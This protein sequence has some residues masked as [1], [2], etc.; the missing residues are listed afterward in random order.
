MPSEKSTSPW[1]H[2]SLSTQ[3]SLCPLHLCHVVPPDSP[4]FSWQPLNPPET[5]VFL[6]QHAKQPFAHY[7]LHTMVSQSASQ[8]L[9]EHDVMGILSAKAST[10]INMSFLISIHCRTFPGPGCSHYLGGFYM[11]VDSLVRSLTASFFWSLRQGKLFLYCDLLFPDF[12][13]NKYCLLKLKNLVSVESFESLVCCL[14][15]NNID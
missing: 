1:R 2:C 12:F 13:L 15:S 6:T 5:S 10:P 11:H 7:C 9:D 4:V 8:G 14:R 3:V